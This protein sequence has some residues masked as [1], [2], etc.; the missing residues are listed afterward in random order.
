[1]SARHKKGH[2]KHSPALVTIILLMVIGGGFFGIHLWEKSQSVPLEPVPAAEETEEIPGRLTVSYQGKTYQLRDDLET[3]LIIGLDKFTTTLSDPEAYINNQQ[4]DFLLLMVVDRTAKSYCAVHINRDTMAEI[5]RLGVG[6]K[7]L[8]A[9]RA[10]LA[11]AHTYGSGGKDSCRNTV[12]AVSNYLYN[13]PVDHYFSLTMDALPILNDLVGG[14]TVHIDDD[15]SAIDPAL[16]QGKDIR[17]VGQQALTFI[18]ARGGVGDQSNLSRMNRQREYM[19]GL[20]K[21]ISEKLHEI[22]GFASRLAKHLADFC[23]SDLT[24]EQL[25]NLADRMKDYRF[26]TIYTIEGEAVKGE[27]FMEFYADDAALQKLVIQLF[28]KE[29]S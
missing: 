10:Q 8:G 17:L 9:Y 23:V 13:V 27:D 15:F 12:D 2:K 1:M 7:R 21:Q 25:S 11:L 5:Q 6:G 28:F 14:V 3:Y 20:Y 22:S 16:E 24:T 4:S 29:I 18:R 26:T 19:Y